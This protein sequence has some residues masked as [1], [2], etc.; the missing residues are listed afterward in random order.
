[1]MILQ[2][3]RGSLSSG[4]Q[5][6]LDLPFAV[7]KSLTAR[8]GPTP[9]FTRGSAGTYVGSDGLIHGIDTST[10]SAAFGTGS[11][12]F[13]LAATADQDQLWRAGDVVEISNAAG[14]L[15]VGTVTS[16]TASTQVLVC[17]ITSSGTTGTFASWRIRY[18]GPRFDH[19]PVTGVCKGL[20]ME[21]SR[22]NS[23]IDSNAF[24]NWSLSNSTVAA[25]SVVNPEGSL[26]AWKVVEDSS[27]ATHTATRSFTPISGTTYTS[28]IWLKSAENGFA[29]VGFSGG[30]FATTFISVNL[31]TGV[32]STA[33]GTPLGA[34]SVAHSNGWWR[35]S[36]SLVATA[37]LVS[38]I[39]I[40]LSRDGLWANRSYLGNG[41][42]GIY[43]YGAQ[44]ESGA[45][46]TS[47]IPTTTASVIRSA[48]VCSIDSSNFAGIWNGVDMTMFFKGSRIDNKTS[49]VNWE[50][51]SGTSATSIASDRGTTTERITANAVGIMQIA[52][53]TTLTE[54]KIAAA[55]KAGD[56]A[57]SFNGA[58]A[59]S[60]SN[61]FVL[62]L[63]RMTIGMN[64]V[65][66]ST[67]NGCVHSI[68]SYKKRLPN[69]KLQ[70]LTV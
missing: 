42:N 62:T 34:T 18:R 6:S 29:F 1:M 22:T 67:L 57:V 8:I 17:N 40:R 2:Q 4:D 61:A 51:T 12:T 35:V 3:A 26:N 43:C 45:F 15:M 48:D 16:Y 14:A 47:Y 54:Y 27:L 33:L 28:S 49:Q 24:N 44:V 55:L 52:A 39:D 64:R 7:T 9:T 31:S 66:S 37:A 46:P 58:A 25:S 10:S 19:D 23:L 50:L 68:Q 5:L 30:G 38:N 32:V 11:K 63:N 13:T 69:S 70:T 59:I 53:F 65:N 20:L 41:V 36:F 21:E 56:Y 60:S